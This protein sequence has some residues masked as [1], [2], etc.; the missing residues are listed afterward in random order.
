MP[1]SGSV[2]VMDIHNGEI[3]CSVSSPG[4]NPNIFSNDLN[5]EDWNQLK[6]NTKAPFLNRSMSGVY[7][8]GSTIKM[9]VALAG[10]RIRN[11]RL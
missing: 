10:L 5:L 6:N 8:P 2:I 11:Y 1:Q 3:L 4:F 9:A 7:P